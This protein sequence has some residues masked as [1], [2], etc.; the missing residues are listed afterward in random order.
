MRSG[1]LEVA[2]LLRDYPALVHLESVSPLLPTMSAIKRTCQEASA[3]DSGCDAAIADVF[4]AALYGLTINQVSK[5]GG[6]YW[7]TYT[8]LT[9]RRG[10]LATMI[11]SVEGN[12]NPINHVN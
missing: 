11:T 9:V 4:H 12:P 1:L 5:G 7:L 2:R 8:V 10:E 3:W 6:L